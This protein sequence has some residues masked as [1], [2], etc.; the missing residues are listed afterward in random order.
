[1]NVLQKNV[2]KCFIQSFLC[3]GVR[4]NHLLVLMHA[5][6]RGGGGVKTPQMGVDAFHTKTYEKHLEDLLQKQN[7]HFNPIG[8]AS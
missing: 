5:S 2:A 8:L 7:A 1:M 3:V 6:F 4:L